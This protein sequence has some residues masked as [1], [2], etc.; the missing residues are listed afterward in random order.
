MYT[1]ILTCST[2]SSSSSST[3]LSTCNQANSIPIPYPIRRTK[4][5][6]SPQFHSIP[7][8]Q[9]TTPSDR[10]LWVSNLTKT[11]DGRTYQFRDISFNLHQGAKVAILGANGSGKSTLLSILSN[12]SKPDQGNVS[13]RRGAELALVTQELPLDLDSSQTVL[14][15]V[16]TLAAIHT[17]RPAVRVALNYAT[18]IANAET[19][20]NQDE[21]ALENLAKATSLMESHPDAWQTES[22][23][24]TAL[25][26][27]DLPKHKTL[28]Q[29]SGGQKRRVGIAAALVSKPDV[30]LLDEV[31]NHLSIEGIQFLEDFLQDPSL[32]V[33]CI[34]HDRYFVDKVCTTAIWELDADLNQYP[35]GYDNF[36]KEKADRLEQEKKE[37][38]D[39]AKAFRKELE[40][41]RRQ[42]KARGTKSKSRI[43]EV[44]RMQQELKERKN[45]LNTTQVKSLKASTDRLGTDVVR[46]EDITITRGEILVTKDFTYTF[47]RGERVGICGGNGVG[48]STLIRT[49]IGQLHP[50]HGE[51][52][53]GETVRFGHFDQDGIDLTSPLSEASTIIMD[54]KSKDEVRVIDYV[55]DMVSLYGVNNSSKQKAVTRSTGNRKSRDEAEQEVEKQLSKKIASLS[56]S[57]GIDISSQSKRVNNPLLKMTPIGLLDH[58]G[59]DRV[60]QYNYVSHLSGGEKRRLQLMSLLLKNPNFLLLDEVS[61]DLDLNTLTMLEELLMQYTGVLVLCSHDRFMLDRLVDHLLVIEGNGDVS[62]IE[63]KFTD[64]LDAKKEL[65]MEEK[66]VKKEQAAET[67]TMIKQEWKKEQAKQTRKLS[68]KEKREY[69]RLEEEIEQCQEEH[70]ELA[71]KLERDATTAPYGDLA[72]WTERLAELDVEIEQKSDRWI[73]LAEICGD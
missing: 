36:L 16:R 44:N 52:H 43:D 54:G 58:F 51:V 31:T 60:K 57:A 67:A 15:A 18:A 40:W 47:Q 73:E 33:L 50:T 45:K 20:S 12:L 28:N 6:N 41:M 48:K 14:S 37:M 22:Y 17:T 2:I 62:L 29:L 72:T 10:I 35:P 59:F 70:K 63:G 38:T 49:I 3:F 30:L 23:L 5:S 61:N 9:T 42:P 55:N 7:C 69:E 65:D 56:N 21:K 25:T 53:V 68:Y 39:L 1:F 24:N 19:L 26:R 46:L 32:T 71:D 11:H 13:L 66:K 34:S 27:L 8:M 64:Y 4:R